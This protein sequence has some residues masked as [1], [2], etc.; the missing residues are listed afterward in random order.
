MIIGLTGPTGAGKSSLSE[1]A[2]DLGFKV[3]DC[4][5]LARKAT[6][7]GTDCLKALTKAFGEEILNEDKTLNRSAL[8]QKAFITKEK[9]ELL[10]KTVFPFITELVKKEIEGERVLLDAPTLF[11][12]GI[13]SLCDKTVAVLAKKEIRLSRIKTRDNITE[14]AALLRINAGKPDSFYEDKA[15]FI[16]FNNG[17]EAEFISQFGEI[18]NSII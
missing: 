16:V 3:V 18:I 15:D 17:N 8:A 5:K 12:S 2:K 7:K 6:E 4:D 14:E 11:E 1:K 13:D 10:N 9:T